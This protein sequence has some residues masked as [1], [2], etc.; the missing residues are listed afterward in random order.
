[1]MIRS[2]I[3]ALATLLLAG[4]AANG[5][6][7][8]PLSR[9]FQWADV[10][11]GGDHA[12]HDVAIGDDSDEFPGFPD[13]GQRAYVV[14]VHQLGSEP[15][16]GRCPDRRRL[17]RH[18]LTDLLPH[19]APPVEIG[20]TFPLPSLRGGKPR[21]SPTARRARTTASTIAEPTSM[22][23]QSESIFPEAS[24]FVSSVDCP[25]PQPARPT[26]ITRV[27]IVISARFLMLPLP[28]N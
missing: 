14:P 3:V 10:M 24:L 5:V 17:G 9:H 15:D 18:D 6:A 25:P 27:A 7:D 21:S 22:I 16:T 26:T 13:Y 12:N 28:L 19:V 1:M 20:F 2:P 8:D 4:C 23:H 11:A